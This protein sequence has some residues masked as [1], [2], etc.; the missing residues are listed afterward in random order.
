MQIYLIFDLLLRI[1]HASISQFKFGLWKMI[2]RCFY[3]LYF[4]EKVD[5]LQKFCSQHNKIFVDILIILVFS[6][7]DIQTYISVLTQFL[8]KKIWR[9]Y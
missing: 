3:Q 1:A 4:W 8:L 7:S 5:N 6:K 9:M 2:L